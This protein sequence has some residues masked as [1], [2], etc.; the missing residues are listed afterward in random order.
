MGFDP[1][2]H[3]LKFESPLDSN[4]Q[5]GSS[6]GSVRVLSLTFS[7]TPRSMKCDSRASFLA[8]TFAS[9]CLGREP[10]AR[11]RTLKLIFGGIL[12]MMLE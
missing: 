9:P 8:H 10:K 12:S 5:N 3:S 7:Y 11:L 1:C 6:L 4:S 2:N